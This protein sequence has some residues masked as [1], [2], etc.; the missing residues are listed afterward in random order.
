MKGEMVSSEVREGY[1]H[2][3][4]IA[5]QALGQAGNALLRNH[6]DEWRKHLSKLRKLDWSRSN[7]RLWEGRA[8]VGGRV[9]KGSTNLVLT[10]NVIKQ[11]LGLSLDIE[12]QEIEDAYS[13]GRQPEARLVAAS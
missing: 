1:I 12:Q 9:I 10:T 13:G 7:A 2:S 6:P 3:H 8:L 4:G 11:V 5:L